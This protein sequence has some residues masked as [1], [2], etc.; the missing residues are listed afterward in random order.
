MWNRL[1]NLVSKSLTRRP[2]LAA[3]PPPDPDDNPELLPNWCEELAM[4][5]GGVDGALGLM[6]E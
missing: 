5:V 6:E 3:V 1:P 4:C 2:T